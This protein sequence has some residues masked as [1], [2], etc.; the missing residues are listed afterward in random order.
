V[1]EEVEKAVSDV[2]KDL[3]DEGTGLT[4]AEKI[5]ADKAEEIVASEELEV[6]TEERLTEA[7]GDKSESTPEDKPADEKDKSEEATPGDDQAVDEDKSDESTPEED[8]DKPADEDGEEK[9]KEEDK[10]ADDKSTP[11]NKS[12]IPDPYIR[13]AIHSGWT[14][15]EI[16]SLVEKDPDLALKT[17]RKMY[18]TVNKSSAEFAHFGRQR[19]KEQTDKPVKKDDSKS[20]AN[21]P[22]VD[23][24]ALKKEYGDDPI[25]GVVEKLVAKMNTLA[26]VSDK[27]ETVSVDQV[28]ANL[29]EEDSLRVQI[30]TFFGDET[31]KTYNEFYGA[32]PKGQT[33]WDKLTTE[34]QQHRWD[35]I[36]LADQ[37]CHGAIA[38][39][40]EITVE[41][42]MNRA[43]LSLSQSVLEK[44]IKE[45]LKNK[46]KG[47][48]KTLQPKSAS[49]VK[50]DK[51]A[52]AK[53]LETKVTA[54]LA[55]TFGHTK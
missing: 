32:I 13:A 49:P 18:E 25:V 36:N 53:D 26:P 40:K 34:Q 41:E 14:P 15:E 6:K 20:V 28:R 12:N 43:H 9:V 48:T 45:D 10:P 5:I 47:R 8:K 39:G 52:S 46:V 37:I 51:Q 42:A 7:F 33:N 44:A 35:V 50:I 17:C 1:S 54:K 3:K 2:E 23:I 16:T 29:R 27:K 31:M 38:L 55:S 4:P 24:T 11:E 22:D 21:E 19:I 30:N